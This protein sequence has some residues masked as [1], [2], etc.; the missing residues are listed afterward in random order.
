M[1]A[2]IDHKSFKQP[3]NPNLKLWRYMDFKKFVSLI[4]KK[5]LFF[6]RA[7][8]F[9]DPYEGS[10]SQAN[11]SMRDKV[12]SDES[13][14]LSKTIDDALEFQNTTLA[15]FRRQWYYVNCWH[16]NEFESAAMWDLYSDGDGAIAI[17]TNYQNLQNH[18]PDQCYMGLINYID[19]RTEWLPEGN[20]FYPFMHKRKSFMHENEVRVIINDEA[21][22][23]TNDKGWNLDS[24]N[25]KYGEFVPIELNEIISEITI[26]PLTPSWMVEAIKDVCEKYGVSSPIKLSDLYND[27][28]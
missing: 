2:I 11:K 14:T 22:I 9:Q 5:G 12:Y 7:D 24:K 4:S 27:P 18:L 17:Q 19:Y 3:E 10:Y 15:K 23:P 26:S 13:G 8:L 25:P 28:F 20:T 16:A 21:S 1:P 6:C